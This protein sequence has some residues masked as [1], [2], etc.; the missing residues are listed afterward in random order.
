VDDD[1]HAKLCMPISEDAD[2]STILVAKA[3]EET[4]L[5]ADNSAQ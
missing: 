5:D 3:D 1:E 4:P 2:P